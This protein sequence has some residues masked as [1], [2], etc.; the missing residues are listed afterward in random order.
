MTI[1]R[2]VDRFVVDVEAERHPKGGHCRVTGYWEYIEFSDLR[3]GDVFRLWDDDE[4]DV[5]IDGRHDVCV[6]LSD[7][8][9]SDGVLGIESM[10]INGFEP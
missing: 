10:H 4:P 3:K 2:K 6:A 9:E 1:E 5:L 8:E 7:P